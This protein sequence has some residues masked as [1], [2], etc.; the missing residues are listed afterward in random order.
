MAHFPM[1]STPMAQQAYLGGDTV[2]GA[3]VSRASEAN[4]FDAR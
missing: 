4:R 1:N 2:T 3:R